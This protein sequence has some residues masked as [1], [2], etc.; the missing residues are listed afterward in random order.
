MHTDAASGAGGEYKLEEL[1]LL[2]EVSRILDRAPD[3][4]SVVEPVLETLAK[5]GQM[6]HGTI[7]LLDR[8]SGEAYIDAAYGLSES[9]R[10][11]GRYKLGE[12]VTG[13]VVQTGR[14]AV[15]PRITDEPLFLDK[16]GAH[17]GLSGTDVA[18]ICVPIR[19][20]AEVIGALSASRSGAIE[21]A[22]NLRLLTI[23]SSMLAQAVQLR[24]TLLDERRALAR[25][26]HRLHAELGTRWRPKNIIGTSKA[27]RG[28]YDLVAQVAPS[29]A[30]VLLHGESG[31]GKELVAQALH[32]NSP[33]RKGPFVRVN[34][35]ALSDS[36][37]ES[38]LFGH[39]RGAF[40]GAIARR[41][42]RF[43][44]ADGGTIFLDEIGDFSPATQVALL[45]V[46]QE[47]EFE[48]V[49][50]SQT[51]KVN[52]RVIA[53]TSRNLEDRMRSGLFREDLYYRLN[54]FPIPVPN[55]RERKTDIPL[56]VDHFI[57]KYSR[58][59]GS[60]VRRISTP[61]I[62]MLMKYHWPGNVR[63]LANCIE[64]AVLLSTDEVIRAHHLPPTLQTAESS[65]T[66]HRGTLEEALD[67]LERE[68]LVDALKNERG[69][70]AA[71]ARRLGI[72]ERRMGLRMQKYAL[73]WRQFR[74]PRNT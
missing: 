31:V 16:T 27:M 45:R 7:T 47:K 43:E 60:D 57:E 9:A 46:L 48:R 4:E 50:S 42:G 1:R 54:V 13:R 55:L 12:G 36:L 24:S 11:K 37:V 28:V 61:A 65:G 6:M 56:L 19:V 49:G 32:F 10:R 68:L 41:A 17:S 62:D 3:L 5:M 70:M 26:N 40:T 20:G 63:E 25:E 29:H 22:D 72:T 30:T 21:V 35:A 15:V 53:A 39:E 71:A 74:T 18:F 23:V 52:V 73:N 2:S 38:E 33:R 66:T 58:D 8:R 14:P 67:S 44:L 51:I 59:T 34:C 64:R 69:N